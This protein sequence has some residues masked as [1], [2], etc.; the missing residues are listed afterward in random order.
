MADYNKDIEDNKGKIRECENKIKD[1]E[2]NRPQSDDDKANIMRWGQEIKELKLENEIMGYKRDVPNFRTD[3]TTKAGLKELTDKLEDM[4]KRHPQEREKLNQ[5]LLELERVK[6]S[7]RSGDAQAI[8][9]LAETV[10]RLKLENQLRDAKSTTTRVEVYA[11]FEQKKLISTLQLAG[12]IPQFPHFKTNKWTRKLGVRP[13]FFCC[14]LQKHLHFDLVRNQEARKK[15]KLHSQSS[16]RYGKQTMA[17]ILSRLSREISRPL[18][19]GFWTLR[20]LLQVTRRYR[21]T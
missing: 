10:E 2:T 13:F 20:C 7:P 5:G 14:F 21:R 11:D 1:A 15:S 9:A 8:E 4:Q 6:A 3:A 18:E 17:A 19:L 16:W 12:N